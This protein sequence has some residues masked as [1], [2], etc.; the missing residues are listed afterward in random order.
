MSSPVRN[1]GPAGRDTLQTI[2]P[3]RRT[4]KMM[5]VDAKPLPVAAGAE[6]HQPLRHVPERCSAQEEIMMHFAELRHLSTPSQ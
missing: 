4:R 1:T 5:P 2:G 3:C 6:I